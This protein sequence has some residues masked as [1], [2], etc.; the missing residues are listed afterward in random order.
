[1]V[2]SHGSKPGAL[3]FSIQIREPSLV[4]SA[5]ASGLARGR[6]GSTGMAGPQSIG[7]IANCPLRLAEHDQT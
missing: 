6:P 5:E 7:T 3:R 2:S 1:M 4:L